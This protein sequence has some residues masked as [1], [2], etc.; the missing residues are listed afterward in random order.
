MNSL[1]TYLKEFGGIRATGAAVQSLIS[2]EIHAH[3]LA[4]GL[5]A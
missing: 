4:Y 2:I 3:G 1:E 5:M